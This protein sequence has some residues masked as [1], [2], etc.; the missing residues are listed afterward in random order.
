MYLYKN[1]RLMES[2]ICVC[3][4]G[5]MGRGIALAAA[6]QGISVTVYDVNSGMFSQAA[7]AIEKELDQALGKRGSR[8]QTK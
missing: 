4:A 5:I 3:G 8:Y 7:S 2:R 6:E 1:H